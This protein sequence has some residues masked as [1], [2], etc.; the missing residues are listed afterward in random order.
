MDTQQIQ[1][2]I[3]NINKSINLTIN[4]SPFTTYLQLKELVA[5][6]LD[7]IY[8]CC[9]LLTNGTNLEENMDATLSNLNI[10]NEKT[11][12]FMNKLNVDRA[13]LEE[14]FRVDGHNWTQ[15]DNWCTDLPLNQW[16]GIETNEDGKIRQIQLHDNKVKVIPPE[17]SK[18]QQLTNLFLS[19]NEI[20]VIPPELSKLQQLQHLDLSWN[21]IKV[22]P[23]ELSKLQQLVYLHLLRNK[24]KVIPK[25]I[26][27]KCKI[28][29]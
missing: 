3:T 22:V 29:I 19:C 12:Y 16:H 10:H 9:F 17:L 25:Q 1:L 23:P 28:Y 5:D 15:H 2:Y 11:L 26:K 21:E 14:W 6:K 20:E 27:S 13:V 8:P 7:D 18:L 24:I 4:C